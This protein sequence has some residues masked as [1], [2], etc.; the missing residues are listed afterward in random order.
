MKIA[1]V[2]LT[3]GASE[4]G[5]QLCDVIGG[6]LYCKSDYAGAFGAR[7]IESL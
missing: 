3:R 5:N 6:T 7:E 1:V 4:L 2:T